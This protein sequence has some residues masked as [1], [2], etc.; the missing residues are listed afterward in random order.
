MDIGFFQNALFSLMFLF[1][2]V[3]AHI[4]YFMVSIQLFSYPKFSKA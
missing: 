3:L 1:L 2:H 4:I